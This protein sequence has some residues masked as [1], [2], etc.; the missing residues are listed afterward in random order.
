MFED[1]TIIGRDEEN[2]FLLHCLATYFDLLKGRQYKSPRSYQ[3]YAELKTRFK[4]HQ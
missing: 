4:I 1:Y 3:K 2:D